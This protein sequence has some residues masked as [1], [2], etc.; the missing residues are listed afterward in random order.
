MD[1][2]LAP[3]AGKSIFDPNEYDHVTGDASDGWAVLL[4]DGI[5]TGERTNEVGHDTPYRWCVVDDDAVVRLY[6]GDDGR[7]HDD[8]KTLRCD[9]AD[10]FALRIR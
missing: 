7:L 8:D 2:Y 6:E 3:Y 4:S 5:V 9:A 10:A 1:D